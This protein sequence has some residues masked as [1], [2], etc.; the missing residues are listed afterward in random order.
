VGTSNNE[1]T[2][3]ERIC[4]PHRRNYGRRARQTVTRRTA[5]RGTATHD[6]HLKADRQSL[7]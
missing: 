7:P 1:R 5:M 2:L 6:S 3:N 4:R